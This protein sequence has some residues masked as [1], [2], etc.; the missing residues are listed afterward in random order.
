[1]LGIKILALP[2]FEQAPTLSH[3]DLPSAQRIWAKWILSQAICRYRFS[4]IQSN[5]AIK[6]RVLPSDAAQVS[7]CDWLN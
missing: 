7:V 1:M 2:Q 6:L 5:S 3:L 4:C